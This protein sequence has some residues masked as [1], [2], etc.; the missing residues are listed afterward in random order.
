MPEYTYT[1]RNKL[2][3]SEHDVMSALNEHSVAEALRA[4]GLSP[5]AI[6]AVRKS[7]DIH[8][9]LEA[10]T[11]IKL[12]DKITFIKNLSVMLRAGLPAARCLKIL[13]AQTTNPK[14]A[15]I[16]SELGRSVEGGT[17]L[18]DAMA[19]YPRVFSPIFVSMVRVGEVSGNLEKN[20]LYLSEQMQ[21][22]YDLISKAR[23]ALTYPIIVMVALAI[24]G[25]L[26][27]TFVLPK[28]TATFNDLNVQLPLMTRVVMATVDIFAR[29]GIL[30][31]VLFL[32]MIIGFFYWRK[33]ES[34]KKI[35]HKLVFYIPISSRIVKQ[36][37]L[38]R[39]VRTFSSLIKSG[40]QIVEALE[41]SS[42][43]VGNIYYQK[44]I[45]DAAARVK[46]GSPLA[47]SF[48][49]QPKLFPNLVVEMMEVGEES[50]TTDQV[51]AEVANFYETEVDQTMKNLSTILEPVI[52]MVI[53]AVVGLLAIALVT[54]I[55]NITQSIN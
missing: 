29:Y 19:K 5:T 3:A 49:K 1:A 4:R 48:K 16:I 40:M 30:I 32:L 44:V 45:S 50:G 13:S 28:L 25:F 31:F 51:L 23:G 21:R 11:T 10:I 53:G 24:V 35:V 2:G 14:F 33:T 34:G 26:M 20:L 55:Y 54:P 39:F 38:A 46:V 52:M 17:T 43:V 18:A 27:F 22:D 36:I 41:V 37:N 15:K 7:F 6:S 42:H 12:I 47:T 8:D 9:L